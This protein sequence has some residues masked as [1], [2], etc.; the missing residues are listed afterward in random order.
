MITILFN[1]EIS[2]NKTHVLIKIYLNAK[3]FSDV[4]N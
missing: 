1:L 3:S 4:E 2:S